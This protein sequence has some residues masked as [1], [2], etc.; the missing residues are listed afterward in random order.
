[1]DHASFDKNRPEIIQLLEQALKQWHHDDGQSS[2]AETL[3]NLVRQT[4]T[5]WQE[6]G[7]PPGRRL[8]NQLLL[9][10]LE[11]LAPID[12][13]AA[14][15]LRRRY[16]DD[17]TGFAVANFL[18]V[19]ESSFYRQRRDALG[20]LADVALAQ[21]RQARSTRAGKLENRLEPPT[22]HQLVGV[23]D[24]QARLSKL[25]RPQADIKLICLAG[26]GG[27]GKTA[28]V[29]RL[30][31][32]VIAT[33][34]FDDLAWIS[35]RQQTFAAWGDV[36][37][38]GQPVLTPDE[39]I[40]QLNQQLTDGLA[41]PRPPAESLAA[42]K[43]RLAKRTHLIIIDNLETAEDYQEILPLL[44]ELGQ[45]AWLLITSRVSIHE[46][47]DIHVT[48]LEELSPTNV[49][50]LVRDEAARRGI[51]DLAAAPA[52]T[53]RQIYDVVG[54][55]P[56]ALKLIIGQVHVRS[57]SRVLTDLDEARGR[58]VE[59]LYEFIYRQAWDLL[60]DMARRVLLTM[61]LVATPGATLDHLMGATSLDDDDLYNALDL[62]IR[63]SLVNVSG[64]LDERRYSIH[65]LT[66]SFLHKQVTKWI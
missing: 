9:D 14:T 12:P 18:G 22:Y 65:R 30:A 40:T 17:E 1:M 10:L 28:L 2:L 29:D 52:E 62:L 51:D 54:G 26:M 33:G 19:S 47:P 23:T 39:L 20:T 55:N 43:A 3:P 5:N 49:E 59:A 46:Q 27:L 63:L 4:R 35:A 56:L 53:M 60:D 13:E 16:I 64:P 48:N 32:E 24:L 61:P 6:S 25:L 34:E 8:T 21:E 44:H 36:Q 38:T 37:A 66:E 58:R 15:L 41:P 45:L 57:L 31:R 42:L 11:E 7:A 50:A